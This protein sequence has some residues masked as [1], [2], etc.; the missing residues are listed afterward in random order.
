VSHAAAP[1][2]TTQ[3][4]SRPE[5]I[6]LGTGNEPVVTFRVQVPE[7][8]DTIRVDAPADTPVSVVKERALQALMPDDASQ[9]ADYVMKLAGWE[10]LD[11]RVSLADAGAK[12][13]SIFLLTS[14]R[15]RPVR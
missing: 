7:V 6:R 9:H 2:F 10:V 12:H 4:R 5:G 11:E 8:W 15:R 13:G 14:R 1:P 3:L